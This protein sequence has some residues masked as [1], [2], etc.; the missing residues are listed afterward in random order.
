VNYPYDKLLHY[1][2]RVSM[3]FMTDSMMV[4]SDLCVEHTGSLSDS[5]CIYIYTYTVGLIYQSNIETSADPRA[6]FILQQGSHVICD[7]FE[8]CQ[9]HH[10][11]NRTLVNVVAENNRH[12]NITPLKKNH[13]LEA[14]PL[15]F[16]TWRKVT[17][18]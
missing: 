15:E 10:M 11:N 16:T 14:S 13:D 2:L 18:P 8:F 3:Q 6:K 5:L 9:S 17:R 4:R 12:L 1:S 7:T